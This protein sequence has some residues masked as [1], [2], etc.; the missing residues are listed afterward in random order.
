M[1]SDTAPN[2]HT[3]AHRA[4]Q[5]HARAERDRLARHKRMQ[6]LTTIA[7]TVAVLGLIAFAL[8]KAVPTSGPTAA[9]APGFT[10]KTTA[11]TTVSLSAYRGKPVVL[12]FNEGAGCAACTM[13][14][15]EIEKDPAFRASG[16]TVLPIVMNTAE[17]IGPDLQQYGVKTPYLL[18]D[19][20]TSRA[21]GTLGT[22][23]HQG[24]PGHGFVL[25]D[26]DG[27]KRWFGNYPS[28]F[29]APSELLKEVSAHL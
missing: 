5:E 19:G 26:S 15:A 27:V 4:H 21:Y 11:G 18:D 12:Y 23:M 7:I 9:A 17:Q 1:S 6:R 29:V 3:A 2:R 13:Q 10:M 16:I 24:L 20:A 14:M 22:G 28:M 25:I 8:A